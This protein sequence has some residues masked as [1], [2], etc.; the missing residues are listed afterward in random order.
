MKT[1][2][3]LI[4]S[5]LSLNNHSSI[6]EENI[7]RKLINIR[8]P[9]FAQYSSAVEVYSVFGEN[10]G[11]KISLFENNTSGKVIIQYKVNNNKKWNTLVNGQYVKGQSI[12][13]RVKGL[14]GSGSVVLKIE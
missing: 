7:V 13:C 8:V 4:V 9:N 3:I 10:A 14:G 2:I 5:M 6:N 12:K 11:C 1:L